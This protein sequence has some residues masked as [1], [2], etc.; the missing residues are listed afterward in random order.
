MLSA[1]HNPY[2]KDEATAKRLF[3]MLRTE[4]HRLE[5]GDAHG[6]RGGSQPG[7]GVRLDY[8]ARA[9]GGIRQVTVTPEELAAK[10]LPRG[11]RAD[12]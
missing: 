1:V 2:S 10:R 6:Q 4:M 5:R 7:G 9:M 12:G 8:L 3:T 11:P